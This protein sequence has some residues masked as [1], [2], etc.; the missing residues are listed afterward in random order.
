MLALDQKNQAQKPKLTVV[1]RIGTTDIPKGLIAIKALLGNKRFKPHFIYDSVLNAH[2][3][4]VLCYT[5]GLS[6]SDISKS[7][8]GLTDEQRLGIQKAVLQLD[9]IY[10]AFNKV[11][12]ISPKLFLEQAY[13]DTPIQGVK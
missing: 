2:Q 8:Y 6:K 13:E 10:K 5:A 12:A 4:A 9:K 7:F 1:D 11:N 3:R